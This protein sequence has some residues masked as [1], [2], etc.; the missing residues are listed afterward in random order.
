VAIVSQSLARRLWGEQ[1]AVGRTVLMPL[2]R[3][4]PAPIEVIGVAADARYRTVLNQAPALL[5]VPLLQNYDSIARLM[6]AVDGPAGEFKEPLHRA[7][8]NVNPDLPVRAMSTIQEQIEQSLWDRRA[9][10]S[11]L[12]LFGILALALACTGVH[13]VVAYATSQRSREIGIRMALG[14]ARGEVQRQV[15]AQALRLALAGI[16]LGIPLATFAKPAVAAF[17]YGADDLN[18]GAFGA[19]ALL[20]VAVALAAAALPA[21][22]AASIDPAVVLRAD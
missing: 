22:R 1:N 10:A 17:L 15:A 12:T 16:V 13:A 14:A 9:A 18:A 19:V 5:Y 8:Q 11:V 2:D 21:R 7:I 20:F 3:F 6:V 4:A